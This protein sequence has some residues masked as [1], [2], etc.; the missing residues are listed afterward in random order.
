VHID[1]LRGT[2]TMLADKLKS[3]RETFEALATADIVTPR[4]LARGRGKASH[5]GCA[6]PFLAA[7]CPSLTQAMHQAESAF[8]LPP[9]PQD[10]EAAD[11][12]FDWEAPLHLSP[13]TRAAL[14]LMLR[15]VSELGSCGQPIWPLLPPSAYGLFLQGQ[16]APDGSPLLSVCVHAAPQGWGLTVRQR[17]SLA[18]FTLSG[19]WLPARDLCSAPWLAG[20]AFSQAGSPCE[21]S[22]QLALAALMG[23]RAL[24]DRM[25][26][27]G[28]TVLFRI[29]SAVVVRA[30]A[31][32][33]SADPALQDLSMFFQVACMD[34]RLAR[35]LL[36][37]AGSADSGQPAPESSLEL[38]VAD[39]ATAL[40]RDR[41][42]HMA[43]Q[44]GY[45]LTLDLFASSSNTQ[46]AR[47]YSA[48]PEPGASGVDALRQ[49]SWAA[50][51]CPWCSAHCPDFVLLFPPAPLVRAAVN[52]ARQDQAHGI[53][54]L[55]CHHSAPWWRTIM[56]ASLTRVSP[57][58]PFYRI[59]ASA[60]NVSHFRGNPASRLALFHFDFWRGS[61]PRPR[62]CERCH[63]ARPP[64][65]TE[66]TAYAEDV[67]AFQDLWAS[68]L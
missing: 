63:L 36:L 9:P 64:Y 66:S 65:M 26:L 38:S 48:F 47:F 29:P 44:A 8:A 7:M 28:F 4:L 37:L 60:A 45:R 50:S 53:A 3:L 5:Y 56:D 55:P 21:P 57:G 54:I 1:T 16:A 49:P 13:R 25:P 52:K 30:L 58:Q 2:F 51:P 41:V 59:R 68:P 34:L 15:A 43:A 11:P 39:S 40:L 12:D 18:P 32:G 19:P 33:C 22:H 24:A 46:C 27:R 17:A 10:E 23:F 35:P 61:E 6:I 20:P 67:Q 62:P 14:R 31:H 42:G